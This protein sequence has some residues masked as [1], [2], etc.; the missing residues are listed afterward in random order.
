[1]AGSH[2]VRGSNPLGSTT[3]AIAGIERCRRFLYVQTTTGA[4]YLE[5]LPGR[6]AGACA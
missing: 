3:I 1:M 6:S 4:H 2:E 5:Q